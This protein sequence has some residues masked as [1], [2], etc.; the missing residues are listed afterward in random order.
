MHGKK[1]HKIHPRK[2]NCAEKKIKKK[3][4]AQNSSAKK[5]CTKKIR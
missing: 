1:V 2:K 3:I 5:Y 4:S